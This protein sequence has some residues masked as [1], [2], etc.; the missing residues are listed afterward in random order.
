MHPAPR[1]PARRTHRAP[2]ALALAGALVLAVTGCSSSDGGSEGAAP[3]GRGGLSVDHLTI[4]APANPTTSVLR[5]QVHND[6]ARA[7]VL[8]GVAS[9]VASGASIHRTELDAE[10]RSSMVA[11]PTVPIPAR[12]TVTFAPS[13]LHVMVTGVHEDLEVGDEVP[14]VLTFRG[15]GKV[16]ATAEVV[17]PGSTQ[18]DHDGH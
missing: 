10:G 17:P 16:D 11:E 3:A 8:V 5:M 9:P 14:V 18:E 6:G 12:S 7:D 15:A 13:G 2:L 1:P 4:D